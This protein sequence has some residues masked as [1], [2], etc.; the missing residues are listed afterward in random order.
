MFG[1]VNNNHL[2]SKIENIV[3]NALACYMTRAR[4]IIIDMI[5]LLGIFMVHL[6]FEGNIYSCLPYN[7]YF[8]ILFAVPYDTTG[9]NSTYRNT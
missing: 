1:S 3:C 5:Y 9:P 4:Q 8:F 2:L 6:L 7:I